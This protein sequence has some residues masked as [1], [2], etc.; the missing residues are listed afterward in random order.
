MYATTNRP[1]VDTRRNKCTRKN[2]SDRS[3][4]S[5]TDYQKGAFD[6]SVRHG[7][8]DFLKSTIQPLTHRDW[9]DLPEDVLKDLKSTINNF[10]SQR[11]VQQEWNFSNI[12]WKL[13]DLD[14]GNPIILADEKTCKIRFDKIIKENEVWWIPF[15]WTYK[16]RRSFGILARKFLATLA[17]ETGFGDIYN[18][19]LAESLFEY[20]REMDDEEENMNEKLDVWDSYKKGKIARRFESIRKLTITRREI[21]NFKPTTEEKELYDIIKKGCRWIDR[22]KEFSIRD[23]MKVDM[24]GYYDYCVDP[25]VQFSLV[26]DFDLVEESIE[27]GIDA[28]LSS[29]A[30]LPLITETTW[31]TK[32]S[33]YSSSCRTVNDY[34]NYLDELIEG[35]KKF[36]FR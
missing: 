22:K 5:K 3:A 34:L 25:E 12:L 4:R 10:F 21:L 9:M 20:Y 28:E 11:G 29:N 24:E 27:E 17:R 36:R 32:D 15:E 7:G 35:I 6:L 14:I 26:Y 33:G 18:S 23:Y 30:T 1:S 13:K 31:I 16:C 8:T 2:H 19:F